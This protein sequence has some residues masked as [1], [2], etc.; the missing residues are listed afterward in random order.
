MRPTECN[1]LLRY[2][3][4]EITVLHTLKILV[5]LCIKVIE[6]NK[7]RLQALVYGIEAV[8][9]RDFK[10]T[11]AVAGITETRIRG[12]IHASE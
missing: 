4:I 10:I 12:Y 9:Q 5:L 7:A 6:I 1:K 2:N 3:P 8:E 11:R